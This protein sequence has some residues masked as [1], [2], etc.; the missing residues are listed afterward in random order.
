[1]ASI[2][3]TAYPLKMNTKVWM[4]NNKVV[5]CSICQHFI[6]YVVIPIALSDLSDW[7]EMRLVSFSFRTKHIHTR[8]KISFNFDRSWRWMP[9][10]THICSHFAYSLDC[11]LKCLFKMTVYKLTAQFQTFTKI[12]TFTNIVY[13]FYVDS[14]IETLK[15]K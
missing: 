8:L 12:I 5:N 1:M 15:S 6:L 3:Q 11:R 9:V 14:K 2:R 13:F 7:R 4:L 10:F